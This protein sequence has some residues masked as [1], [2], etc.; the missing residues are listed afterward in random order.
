MAETGVEPPALA[1][2]PRPTEWTAEYYR[3]YLYL[4]DSR[5]V[6][7]G[8]VGSVPLS[9]MVALL[10][11]LDVREPDER[12]T[13]VRMLRALDSVY[14]RSMAEKSSKVQEAPRARK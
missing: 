3:G 7:M 10:D 1:N 8:S 5:S 11:L 6:G 4:V 14:V 2:R 13:W 12:E 9:E